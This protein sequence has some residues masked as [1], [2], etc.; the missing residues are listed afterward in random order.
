MNPCHGS[1]LVAEFLYCSLWPRHFKLAFF[2]PLDK[3]TCSLQFSSIPNR[4]LVDDKYCT[5]KCCTICFCS[6]FKNNLPKNVKSILKMLLR[7]LFCKPFSLGQPKMVSG[8]HQG[9]ENIF[10]RSVGKTF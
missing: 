4:N 8:P 6:L 7:T 9:G 5:E 1:Y 3:S 2:Y 10:T